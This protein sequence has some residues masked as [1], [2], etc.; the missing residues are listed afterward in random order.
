MVAWERAKNIASK[1]LS[2]SAEQVALLWNSRILGFV[3]LK[4]SLNELR[5]QAKSRSTELITKL[6][7]EKITE[8][9]KLVNSANFGAENKLY[10]WG[11]EQALIEAG[12]K[13]EQA[14]EV[15]LTKQTREILKNKS[16]WS[17]YITSLETNAIKAFESE[18]EA[19]TARA[20]ELANKTHDSMK[21]L[22]G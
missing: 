11:L 17:E 20:F 21:K 8:L 22:R 10:R 5:I 15:R 1:V 3:N 12:Q 4:S 9:A 2:A 18:F 6:R 7:E 14:M 13:C 19:K 16:L